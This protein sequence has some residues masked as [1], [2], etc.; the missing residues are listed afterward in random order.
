MP[1]WRNK[2]YHAFILQVAIAGAPVT[3]WKLYDTGYT[4]RYMGTPDDNPDGYKSGSVLEY[5]SKFP[6]E[7]VS[8]NL[9]ISLLN[10]WDSVI[11]IILVQ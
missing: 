2:F 1:L 6:S 10:S 7:Y 3:S 4:E 9:N 5:V 11:R 8:F